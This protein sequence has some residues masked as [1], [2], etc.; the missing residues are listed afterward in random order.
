MKHLLLFVAGLPLLN[1]NAQ[2]DPERSLHEGDRPI[3]ITVTNAYPST[4]SV[5]WVD[6]NGRPQND[7]SLPPG[8][9]VQLDSYPG[10]LWR[11][12]AN[13]SAAGR[14]RATLAK[15]QSY[16]V[17]ETHPPSPQTSTP[18][19]SPN[20]SGNLSI[21]SQGGQPRPTLG[22]QLWDFVERET[23]VRVTTNQPPGSVV[24]P[25][26]GL[27]PQSTPSPATQV[28]PSNPV[29]SVT[30]LATNSTISAITQTGSKLSPQDAQA[31]VDYHNRVRQEV[32][33]GG[34]TWNPQIAAFAQEWADELAR[35][36]E[37]KHRPRNEQRYGENLA[38]GT[39]GA[40]TVITGANM[41]YDEKKL[42]RPGTAFSASQMAAGHYTQ[43]VWRS[44][45][46]IGAGMAVCQTGRY[47]GWTIL[48]CNYAPQGNVIGQRPY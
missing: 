3:Q 25:N 45:N 46:Q 15:K 36:G 4:V 44:S 12:S 7:G 2:N 29:P 35:R 17:S 42:Y 24:A 23:G 22:Q 16:T 1:A 14:Y 30:S 19:Q 28:S 47:R 13:G 21:V 37:F 6:F 11:F 8:N 41:W 9:M 20:P 10:H 31:L 27:P 40:F 5:L 39:T 26:G 34:V 43:M 33:V 32:G 48:V 18:T 38:G